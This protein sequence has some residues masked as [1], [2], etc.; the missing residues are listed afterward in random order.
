MKRF[1]RI[2]T[3]MVATIVVAM[4]AGAHTRS[5]SY[6]HWHES[7]T[8]IT[9]TITIPLREVMLLYQTGDS[10]VPPAE[11]FRDELVGKTEVSGTS[12]ICSAQRVNILQAASGFVRIEMQFDCDAETPAAIHYRAL[13]DAAPAH[14]HYA[15]LHRGGGVR[16]E[17]LIT[18]TSDTWNIADIG[19]SDSYS[20]T[21][22]LAIGV[23]HIGGGIDH[24]AFL[25]GM[26]MIAGSIGRS[27][28]AV[29]GF[30]LGHSIS[31]GAAVLGYVHAD[32]QLV[33]AFIGFTVALVAVEYFLLRKP[34]ERSAVTLA[35][36]SLGI[37]W[38]VG[39]L[40]ITFDLISGRALF[41]YLGFGVFAFCYLLA[42]VELERRDDARAG[43]MLFIATTCFGLVHGF[44]F[45]GF[46]METGILGTSLFIPLL[47]FNLGVEVGQ[48][49]LV[50]IALAT[51]Y[52]LRDRV[53]RAVTPMLAAS[54]CGVGVYWFIGR[55][56]V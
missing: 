29:T 8:T 10:A 23:G 11:L 15:K 7:G 48:L 55:T 39:L 54:L 33:E 6:S 14:V 26:L 42:S 22:F 3:T 2:T 25:I 49:I 36:C 17:T 46:L 31:L 27:I 18:D 32:S 50:A 21:S 40:A 35:V 12:G 19:N 45:A 34:A 51:A 38:A 5:E 20:F 47:G 56:L 53:S 52:L 41:V 37:A 16:S 4:D 9:A 28:V 43:T 44:G 13:F 30:T 1:C 24:I